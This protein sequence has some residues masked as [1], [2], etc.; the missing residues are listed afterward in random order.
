[1]LEITSRWHL[2]SPGPK[3]IVIHVAATS[4]KLARASLSR[5]WRCDGYSSWFQGGGRP[6]RPRPL[7]AGKRYSGPLNWLPDRC[8]RTESFEPAAS[9]S[10]LHTTCTSGKK[11][12]AL[13]CQSVIW[14][15]K[16]TLKKVLLQYRRT[17]S[18]KGHNK[19]IR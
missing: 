9:P 13:F 10:F 15:P 1:M 17:K 5:Y 2:P 3:K 12:A 14:T 6:A 8:W 16:K 19:F 4:S 7:L 11:S 18:L